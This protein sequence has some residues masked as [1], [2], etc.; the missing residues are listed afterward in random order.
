MKTNAK[1]NLSFDINA[2]KTPKSVSSKQ[3]DNLT[4]ALTVRLGKEIPEES[5]VVLRGT[6]PDSTIF[7]LVGARLSEYEYLFEFT[8]GALSVSGRIVCDVNCTLFENGIA[9]TCST[10]IFFIENMSSAVPANGIEDNT[11]KTIPLLIENA[12]SDAKESGTFDG[13]TAYQYAV[14]GG[15][16][17]SEEDFSKKL[18]E[19]LSAN[20]IPANA[21]KKTV[22]GSVV[23]IDDMIPEIQKIK[24]NIKSKNL[25]PIMPTKTVNGVLFTVFGD[26]KIVISGTASADTSFTIPLSLPADTYTFSMNNPYVFGGEAIRVVAYG[27][28][29]TPLCTVTPD[30]VNKT[31]TFK[32]ESEIGML[33]IRLSNGLE[34]N[35]FIIKPQLEVGSVASPYTPMIESGNIACSVFGK[36]L[37]PPLKKSQTINGLTVIPNPDGTVTVGGSVESSFVN[38]V[39]DLALLG[40]NGESEGAL[41]KAGKVYTLSVLKDGATYAS[42]KTEL[43]YPD[44]DE[45]VFVSNLGDKTRERILKRV[46]LERTLPV[47]STALDGVYSV[48]LELGSARSG[49]EAYLKEEYTSDENGF[50]EFLSVNPTM[51][52]RTENEAAVVELTYS[53]DTNSALNDIKNALKALGADI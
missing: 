46:Y 14:E 28:T 21:V 29:G 45:T 16:T 50:V 30:T 31:Y 19:D 1:I 7:D 52:V 2:S 18:A 17:G 32:S 8:E 11:A 44:T 3:F 34:L 25:L 9:K 51:T 15:F 12:L 42:Y 53:Q 5:V 13:K 4:R 26:G 20:G 43:Y 6:K 24:G 38:T 48:Q 23:R 40:E 27:K 22:L 49:H 37:L 10:E 35:D 39:F 41:L 47:G 36:N 33:S